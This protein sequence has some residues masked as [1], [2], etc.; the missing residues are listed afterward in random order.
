[1]V[2][3]ETAIRSRVEDGVLWLT[4]DRPDVGN[5]LR[6]VDRNDMIELLSEAEEDV[7]VR[8][9]V[10]T[11]SGNAFC[12]GADLRSSAAVRPRPEDAPE[13]IAGDIARNIRKNAQRLIN[14]IFDLEKPVIAA[15][16]GTAAG[17][18]FH[19]AVACDLVVAAEDARFIEVFVRR[20]L[21]PDAGG[22]YLLPRL[23][24][25]QRA[26][27]L[28][29]LGDD[30]SAARAYEMGLVNRVV[31]RDQVLT[32]AGVLAARLASGPT[33]ALALTKWLANRSL[34][35]DRQTM[36][37]NESYAQDINMTTAD[38]NEGL[39]AFIERRAPRFRGW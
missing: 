36:F 8:C 35:S 39:Q 27:E 24:G 31:P 26:K 19:L 23:V 32:E 29:F 13:K 5:A 34:D 17:M 37:E 2:N 4:I 38:G 25:L 1:M 12:T 14:T 18:G 16:N 33:R 21:V 15:V 22:A 7:G 30:L 11:G 20:A 3:E 6:P 10:L 28:M 9:V